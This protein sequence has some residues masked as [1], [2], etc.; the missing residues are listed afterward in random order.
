VALDFTSPQRLLL[1][2]GEDFSS[3]PGDPRDARPILERYEKLDDQGDGIRS[4]LGVVVALTVVDRPLF[5]IDEPEAFL[6]PR[7]AYRMGQFLAEHAR[8]NCQIFA[9][10]HSVDLLRGVLSRTRDVKIVRLDRR[11]SVKKYSVLSADLLNSV[12][13]D[14][15]LSSARVL[16]GPFYHG[17][18]VVEADRDARFDQAVSSKRRSKMDLHFVNADNKQTVPRVLN[19]Y[20]ELGVPCAGI[21][22]IDVLNNQKE[23]LA[24]LAAL[25]L[26]DDRKERTRLM[27]EELV[28]CI[29]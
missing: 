12:I 16:D 9:A 20:R 4:F 7:Q 25:P 11:G 3:I 23:F 6:H 10:T 26:E 15:L 1:R 13:A 24:Q 19:L 17:A 18:V 2:V 22:D 27:R 8:A 28:Q 14:P 21:V 5:L 29:T